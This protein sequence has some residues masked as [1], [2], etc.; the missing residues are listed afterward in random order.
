MVELRMK[1]D[2]QAGPRVGS[3]FPVFNPIA[4]LSVAV[5]RLEGAWLPAELPL[6]EEFFPYQPTPMPDFIAD[7]EIALTRATGRRYLEVGCGLGTKMVIAQAAGLEVH[8]IEARE[9]YAAMARY[10]CPEAKVEIADARYYG[11]YAAFDIV[12]CYRPLISEKG[13]AALEDFLDAEMR[14]D[15]VLILP[16]RGMYRLGWRP[17]VERNSHVWVRS[18]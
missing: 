10:L 3:G 9:Q 18:D 13:T 11:A 7:L 4:A 14:P 12:F 16:Y 6:H 5:E 17:V 15:A 8:G 2:M 1:N